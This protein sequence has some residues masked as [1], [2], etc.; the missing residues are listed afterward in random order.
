MLTRSSA[1]GRLHH[2]M[3]CSGDERL[4]YIQ[5]GHETKNEGVK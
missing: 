2:R 1:V 5:I 4:R 3:T